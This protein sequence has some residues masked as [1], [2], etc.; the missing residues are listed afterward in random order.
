MKLK[1]IKVLHIVRKMDFGGVE[2]WLLG[3]AQELQF[4][5]I[6]IDILVHT[7]EPGILDEKLRNIG[8]NIIPLSGHKNPAKYVF[9][10]YNILKNH[11]P[12][13]VVHSHVLYFSGI[14][15]GAA[16]MAGVPIRISH[17]HSNRS[18]IEPKK[19]L[20]AF[21]IRT[22]K[23]LVKAFANR[24]IAVSQEA[25]KSLHLGIVPEY[26]L[27]ILYCG[28]KHLNNV[29]IDKGLKKALGIA[30]D[31]LVLGHVG[32]MSEP[33]NHKFLLEI[34]SELK[35]K[36]NSVLVLVGDGELKNEIVADINK[37][38]LNDY[39]ILLGSRDDAVDIMASIFDVI[40]FPSLYE[41][42]PLTVVEAQAVG[43][44]IIVSKNITKEAEFDCALVDYLPLT[45]SPAQWADAIL[46]LT[47][48]KIRGLQ[49]DKFS[50]TDFYL[51]NHIT[52]LKNIYDGNM[53][54]TK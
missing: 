27:E 29:T 39:V 54:D 12:Y 36:V 16:K 45:S 35:T 50:A 30:D 41:G 40:A 2:R 28:I 38:G 47:P 46:H 14:V 48:P 3:V 37:L 6:Q 34:F 4:S 7:Y 13:H 18:E 53:N 51:P 9:N 43:V 33:K 26:K 23:L 15:L 22:M 52:K 1:K 5:D 20:R 44:P 19:G 11:G 17:A 21:Y 42:L 32:R 8:V 49:F 10:L 25:H 24:F 31:K